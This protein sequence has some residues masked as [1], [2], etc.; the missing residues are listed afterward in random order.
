ME[1]FSSDNNINMIDDGAGSEIEPETGAIDFSSLEQFG[2]FDPEEA[3]RNRLKSE[4]QSELNDGR[5]KQEILR[6]IDRPVD[7][8]IKGRRTEEGEDALLGASTAR[9]NLD[10]S[11]MNSD[12][13]RKL[14]LCATASSAKDLNE[15]FKHPE[16]ANGEVYRDFA[17]RFDT[18]DKF[19]RFSDG[20]LEM[21]GECNPP[22]K[23]AE[24]AEDMAEFK[25]LMF[26]EQQEAW[27][28][29]KDMEPEEKASVMSLAEESFEQDEMKETRSDGAEEDLREDEPK[30]Y[31]DLGNGWL[32]CSPVGFET[33]EEAYQSFHDGD[34]VVRY[35]VN[36]KYYW[37][38]RKDK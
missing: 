24:Y 29:L 37:A 21:I 15:R 11:K 18:A 19:Q 7:I 2:N 13:F 38:T 10:Q 34:T 9:F 26:G 23:A 28:V 8:L 3:E 1:K 27:D 35:P 5:T 20:F 30:L 4:F 17:N 6:K 33:K 36:G 22:E 16:L 14:L 25:A 32:N 31:Q 12:H